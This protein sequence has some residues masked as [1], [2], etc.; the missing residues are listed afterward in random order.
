MVHSIRLN[1]FILLVIKFK[2]VG[3]VMAIGLK[4][5]IPKNYDV[6]MYN[7]LKGIQRKDK[8]GVKW[9]WDPIYKQLIVSKTFGKIM[10]A[11]LSALSKE[12]FLRISTY[13][14]DLALKAKVYDVMFGENVL[15]VKSVRPS[16]GQLEWCMVNDDLQG[17]KFIGDFEIVKRRESMPFHIPVGTDSI[18]VSVDGV[19]KKLLLHTGELEEIKKYIPPKEEVVDSYKVYINTEKNCI[20]LLHPTKSVLMK[21]SSCV[22]EIGVYTEIIKN[23]LGGFENIEKSKAEK[24]IEFISHFEHYGNAIV[25]PILYVYC[26]ARATSESEDILANMI[27]EITDNWYDVDGKYKV[28]LYTSGSI[29]LGLVKLDS[30]KITV[31]PYMIDGKDGVLTV[32]EVEA[33]VTCYKETGSKT[34]MIN[35]NEAL[36]DETITDEEEVAKWPSP[37]TVRLR[38]TVAADIKV[39]KYQK[40]EVIYVDAGIIGKNRLDYGSIGLHLAI[41]KDFTYKSKNKMR[42]EDW[43]V[44]NTCYAQVV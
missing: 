11:H 20:Q 16:T 37:N 44:T 34:A 41:C 8:N 2:R 9:L 29:I 22:G 12:D 31:A 39:F 43:V 35:I 13:K 40:I 10:V 21:Q 18:V 25:L 24:L 4:Y 17:G 6:V 26:R 27:K 1:T 38:E 36:I 14:G 15:Y 7:G 19:E 23:M 3:K 42:G 32:P 5:S 33:L 30:G 28:K